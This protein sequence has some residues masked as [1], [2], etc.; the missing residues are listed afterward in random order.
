MS[1]IKIGITEPIDV[2]LDSLAVTLNNTETEKHLGVNLSGGDHNF[3]LSLELSGGTWIVLTFTYNGRRFYPSGGN[4]QAYD[5]KSYGCGDLHLA[6]TKTIIRLENVQIQPL[7]E[8][9]PE[10]DKITRFADSTNDC[11]GFFSPAIWGALF[12]VIILVT[13]LST[14]LTMIM[15]IRTMDR[16][17]DPKGKTIIIN[18][19]E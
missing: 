1:G 15:D 4:I 16:F 7:F 19:Q 5:G 3:G 17:D 14:G 2:P 18:T 12:V 8:T 9:T 13:I 11:V 6:D 10:N